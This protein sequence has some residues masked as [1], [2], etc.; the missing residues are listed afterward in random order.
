MDDA[1]RHPPEDAARLHEEDAEGDLD[2]PIM[3]LTTPITNRRFTENY[4]SVWWPINLKNISNSIGNQQPTWS[5]LV[6]IVDKKLLS[7][8]TN[9]KINEPSIEKIK[10]SIICLGKILLCK[11]LYNQMGDHFQAISNLY[12]RCSETT[13]PVQ[14]WI[15]WMEM[16]IYILYWVNKNYF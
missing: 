6:D 1:D 10:E 9:Q 8:R 12:D 16:F 15:I 11:K 14:G 3:I 5:K 4:N 13:K 2:L 7:W